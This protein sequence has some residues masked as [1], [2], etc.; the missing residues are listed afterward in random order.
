MIW[1]LINSFPSKPF[2]NVPSWDALASLSI[3]ADLKQ[4]SEVMS[5]SSPEVV[6]DVVVSNLACLVVSKTEHCFFPG[7][8]AP[9]A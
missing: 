9:A 1:D 7:T 5:R 3:P 2:M 4:N 8:A 6:V